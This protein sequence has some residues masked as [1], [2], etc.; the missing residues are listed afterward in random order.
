MGSHNLIM[1]YV[2]IAHDCILGDHIVIANNTHFAG[3]VTVGSRV[4]I[5]GGGLINQFANIGKGA[6]IAGDSSINKDILP[7]TTAQGKYAVMRATNRV[8]LERAGYSKEDREAINRAVRFIIK[9]SGTMDEIYERIAKDCPDCEGVRDLVEFA[10][11]SQRGLARS[12]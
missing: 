5:G 11:N 6:Y 8:G 2:H 4:V 7:F 10:K 9:G 12:L 1:A 3:H